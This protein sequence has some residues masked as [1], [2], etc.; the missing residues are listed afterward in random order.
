MSLNNVALG[1]VILWIVFVIILFIYLLKKYTL[2]E[3][4]PNPYKDETLGMPRGVMRAILT[5]SVLFIV[6]LLEVNGMFFDPKELLVGGEIFIPE[7]RFDHILVAFQ[8]IIAFYFGSKVMHHMT[9]TQKK[10]SLRKSDVALEEAKHQPPSQSFAD[11]GAA[12]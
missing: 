6:L 9:A 2:N 12:G 7:K 5:L 3:D 11:E 1:V 10:I 4:K 8:M